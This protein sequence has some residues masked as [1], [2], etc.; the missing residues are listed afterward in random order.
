M[1]Q[2][3]PLTAEFTEGSLRMVCFRGIEILRGIAYVVRDQ[4]WG[5]YEPATQDCAIRQESD[6][7]SVEFRACCTDAA[8]GQALD[9]STS[10]TGTAAGT[11]DFTVTATPRTAFTTARCGFAVLHPIDGVAGQPVSVE[12]GD[13]SREDACFPVLIAPWQPFKDIRAISHEAAPG[14]MAH[15][16]FEGDVFEME[17]Q[18]A[19]SDAS[20][21]TYV[22]PLERPWPYVM[23]AGESNL[24]S[25]SL[26]IIDVRGPEALPDVGVEKSVTRISAGALQGTC[27]AIGVVVHPDECAA[28]LAHPELLMDLAPALLQFHLDPGAGHG[29]GHLAAFAAVA[30]LMPGL[31]CLLEIAVPAQRPLADEMREIAK[32]VDK[33]GLHLSAIMVSP[34]VDRQSTPPGSRWPECPPLEEVYQA[35]GDA[36]PDLAL[37]GG[38]LSYFT[39]LNRKRPPVDRLDF[40]SHCTCPIVHASDDVSVMQSLAS[41]PHIVRSVRAIID[42]DKPYRIGP[43]TIGMR[44][45]PYG[46]R[47]ME[48]P[49][50]RRMTMTDRD[51]RQASLF[52]AAWMLGYVAATSEGR[53]QSLTVGALTGSLG[54]AAIDADGTML[55]HPVFHTARALAALGGRARTHC[56][57]SQPGKI[58]GLIAESPD[59]ARQLWLAN[60][61]GQAQEIVLDALPVAKCLLLLDETSIEDAGPDTHGRL[62]LLPYAVIG[63]KLA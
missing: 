62:Q 31:D 1:L 58:A 44:Q 11:L 46:T 13:G 55:R 23:E 50:E 7:F 37:G 26:Q 29:A 52:A 15:C 2:A 5:T 60:L 42:P 18:R 41:L 48:N 35:A 61:T 19:W 54:L 3:G 43:S 17:D 53:L 28:V 40:V 45:N 36:F 6:R 24:Q 33:A 22:R 57:S 14:L 38:M 30:A 32:A 25:V 16:R 4:D 12:H 51:P 59:G 21:K 63:L 10:I 20:Y 8:G 47:L 56:Q 49:H 9:Y 34:A 39:E 27:P